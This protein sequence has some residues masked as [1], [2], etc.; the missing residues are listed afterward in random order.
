MKISN[1]GINLIKQFE[2]LSLKPYR[3]VAGVPTIGWGSTYYKDNKKVTMNDKPITEDEANL[4]LEYIAN[5]DF[6]DK[7]NTL[8]KVELNQNQFD[9]LVS[10]CYNLGIGNFKSSTLL[11]K[12]NQD[13][14]KGASEE[15]IKWNKVG[16][17]ELVGL[18]KRR[19]KEKK[20][21]LS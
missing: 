19:E 9:A 21:F 13:D 15:F 4:L 16:K 2:G 5:K 12:I 3:D 7:I 20:L 8:V 14:F 10:F 11:K 17:T 6:G 18:T 1:N